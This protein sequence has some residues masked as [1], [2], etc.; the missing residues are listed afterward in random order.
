[1]AKLN[2]EIKGQDKLLNKFKQFGE[3]AEKTA[4]NITRIAAL[5][6]EA[7]AKRFAPVDTGKLRQS[8]NSQEITNLSYRIFT[9]VKYAPYMEFGTGGLVEVPPELKDLAIQFKGAGIRKVNLRPQ[10]FMWPAFL[11]G[12]KSYIKDLKTA[13][14][15][16]DNR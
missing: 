9:S 10:P 4:E 15:K 1:M 3:K 11:L 12:R 13:L 2:V 8:I 16:L 14:K 7:N 5:D 6:I